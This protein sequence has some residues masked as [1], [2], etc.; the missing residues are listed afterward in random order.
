MRTVVIANQKGGCGKTTTAVNLAA[1]FAERGKRVLM[2]DLD[3][4]GHATLGFGYEPDA[5]SKTIYHCLINAEF[6]ISTVILPT[7]VE[8]LS[9]APSNI[10]LSGAELELAGIVGREFALREQLRTVEHQYDVC[11]IDCPPSLGL[12]TLNALIASTD[13]I[14]P[15]QV[16]YYAME[17]LKQL[18]ETANIIRVNFHPCQVRF[19]GFLLTFVEDRLLFCRQIQQQM[20]EF[21]G[22]LVFRTVIHRTVRLAEAPSAG[23]SIL[24][25]ATQSTGAAEYRSLADEII[26]CPAWTGVA[27]RPLAEP[28]VPAVSGAGQ[29]VFAGLP[30]TP[31]SD[32]AL[33]LT[34]SV[35]S[36]EPTLGAPGPQENGHEAPS[37]QV[38]TDQTPVEPATG[39]HQSEVLPELAPVSPDAS[40]GGGQIDAQ[41]V[42]SEQIA[43]GQ[44]PVE[45]PSGQQVLVGEISDAK[46]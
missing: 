19:L 16:G 15:V 33:T 40:R 35:Q 45:Q 2:A 1:A 42:L 11:V 38:T 39:A 21:F 14:V 22:D 8:S 37:E 46:T 32:P 41:K 29:P 27:G 18:L 30:Q 9:I 26:N 13:V 34:G 12:L 43:A 25:Y 44:T 7:K 17:G 3:P 20:R 5:L 23:E 10:L 31:P 4:Q 24:T 6:P 28:A 36:P